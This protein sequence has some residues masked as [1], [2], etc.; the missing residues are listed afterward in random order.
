MLLSLLDIIALFMFLKTISHKM[1]T[2]V[3]QDKNLYVRNVRNN[4]VI[5]RSVLIAI[6]FKIEY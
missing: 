5:V 4:F 3:V 2:V 6:A 1:K